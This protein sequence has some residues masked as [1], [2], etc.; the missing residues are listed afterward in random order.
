MVLPFRK[1]PF[2]PVRRLVSTDALQGVPVP[3][4]ACVQTDAEDLSR[5]V[6]DAKIHALELQ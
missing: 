5:F 4:R 2:R 1:A 6:C 3:K